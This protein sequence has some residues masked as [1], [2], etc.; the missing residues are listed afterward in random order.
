[1]GKPFRWKQVIEVR[2]DYTCSHNVEWIYK[3]KNKK[4]AKATKRNKEF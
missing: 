3:E 1:M 4:D 2:A